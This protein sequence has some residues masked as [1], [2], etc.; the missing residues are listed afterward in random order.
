M[1]L[2]LFQFGLLLKGLQVIFRKW[3]FTGHISRCWFQTCFMFIPIWGRWTQFDE[4]FF[5]S[6]GSTTNQ[7]IHVICLCRLS[8]PVTAAGYRH[9]CP[10]WRNRTQRPGQPGFVV[11]RVGGVWPMA[12]LC[13]NRLPPEKGPISKG[14]YERYKKSPTFRGNITPFCSIFFHLQKILEFLHK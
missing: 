13:P 2:I 4:C 6:C 1:L 10:A 8:F 9:F 5:R 11:G 7:Y 12:T 3:K 14:I